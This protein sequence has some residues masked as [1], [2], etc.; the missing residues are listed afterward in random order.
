MYFGNDKSNRKLKLEQGYTRNI[1]FVGFI[2]ISCTSLCYQMSN[3][4]GSI[5][6]SLGYYIT[7]NMMT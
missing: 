5:T 7:A 3:I 1:D 6:N 4:F 2:K